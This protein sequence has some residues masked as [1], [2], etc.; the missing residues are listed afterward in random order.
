M[1]SL[2]S[3]LS[4]VISLSLF[5]ED[6]SF[7]L[8]TEPVISFESCS[9]LPILT[10]DPG[11]ETSGRI[12]TDTCSFFSGRFFLDADLH[13]LIIVR[14]TFPAIVGLYPIFISFLS[15]GFISSNIG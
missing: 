9:I 15:E 3:F 6:R 13:E 8:R 4:E 1:L 5:L 10:I 12:V 11:F 14:E 7:L 2:I